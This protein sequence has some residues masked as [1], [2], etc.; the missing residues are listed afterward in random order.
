MSVDSMFKIQVQLLNMHSRLAGTFA[1][2]DSQRTYLTFVQ[3]ASMQNSRSNL[4]DH[5]QNF[6]ISFGGVF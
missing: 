3:D 1:Q 2:L 5:N 4:L 6:K